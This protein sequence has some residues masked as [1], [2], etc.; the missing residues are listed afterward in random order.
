MSHALHNQ[1]SVPDMFLTCSWHVPDNIT[2]FTNIVTDIDVPCPTRDIN[3][4]SVPDMFPTYL[5]LVP[6]VSNSA[7]DL[8]LQPDKAWQKHHFIYSKNFMT[9]LNYSKSMN[10]CEWLYFDEAWGKNFFAVAWDIRNLVTIWVLLAA[11]SN[12]FQPHHHAWCIGW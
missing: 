6:R 9:S 2:L 7:I 12:S 5:L 3:R 1:Y 4:C 10:F 8:N 11:L